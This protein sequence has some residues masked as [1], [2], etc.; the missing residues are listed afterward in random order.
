MEAMINRGGKPIEESDPETLRHVSARLTDGVIRQI[1]ALRAARPRRMGSPKLG[2]SLRD[3]IV[4]AVLE[5]LE[6][7]RGGV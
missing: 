4:E 3:W 7:E 5:K 2:I 6:R 1:D